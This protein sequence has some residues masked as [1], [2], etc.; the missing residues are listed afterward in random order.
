MRDVRP[1]AFFLMLGAL[2]AI[3]VVAVFATLSARSSR[4]AAQSRGAR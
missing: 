4:E 3:F 2:A 1:R